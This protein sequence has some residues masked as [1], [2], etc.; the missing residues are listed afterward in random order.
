MENLSNLVENLKIVDNKKVESYVYV[1]ILKDYN[2]YVGYTKNIARRLYNHF[3]STGS[4][5]TRLHKPIC[6]YEIIKNGTIY[7]EKYK[8]LE[9]MKKFGWEN[10]RGYAWN[11][12]NLKGPPKDLEIKFKLE[13]IYMKSNEI[14]IIIEKINNIKKKKIEKQK[15]KVV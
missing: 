3:N 15:N 11:Q 1:L 13:L 6:I 4:S 14:R 2:Y 8:T 9:L 7:V 12:Y 5:W 10:V